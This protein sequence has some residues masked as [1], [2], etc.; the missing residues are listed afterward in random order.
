MTHIQA[1]VVRT[2]HEPKLTDEKCID[3]CMIKSWCLLQAVQCLTQ[4]AHNIRARRVFEASRHLHIDIF[5]NITVQERG[6]DIHLVQLEV[7]DGDRGEHDAHKGA[8]DDRGI[9]SW[10][11]R[12]CRPS[13]C[14]WQRP[15]RNLPSRVSGSACTVLRTCQ[16]ICSG[17][18]KPPTDRQHSVQSVP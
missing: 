1:R 17:S 14:H 15:L 5:I 6:N 16:I 18:P 9:R 2:A 13:S 4:F 11:R 7:S 8:L 10:S 12:V 3:F